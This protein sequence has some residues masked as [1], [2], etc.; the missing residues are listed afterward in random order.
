MKKLTINGK[1]F[2]RAIRICRKFAA[3]TAT[4]MAIDIKDQFII[5]VVKG[6]D[7]KNPD[8]Q[9][10]FWASDGYRA[11]RTLVPVVNVEGA[12]FIVAI[13]NPVFT[14]Q[15]GSHVS[16]EV[17][18]VQKQLTATVTYHEYGTAFT[19]VQRPSDETTRSAAEHLNLL[20]KPMEIA[21]AAEPQATFVCNTAFFKDA[22]DAAMVANE[23]PNGQ[24]SLA[25]RAEE[26]PAYL[27]ACD[28]QAIVFPMRTSKY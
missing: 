23:R 17:K 27:Q 22:I 25:V 10:W 26:E 15:N 19:T 13:R 9:I 11:V 28:M 8:C 7:K 18:S 14:P 2:S 3:K 20:K 1:E 12:P 16:I 21:A 24:V 5:E 6:K 4:A